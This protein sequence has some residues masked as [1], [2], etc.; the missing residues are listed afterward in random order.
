MFPYAV[1]WLRGYG[2]RQPEASALSME[3]AIKEAFPE[4][5][6][7]LFEDMYGIW[8]EAAYSDH[9]VSEESRLLMKAFMNETIARVN[10]N[11][12]LKDKLRIKLRYAL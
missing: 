10:K 4:S 1:R 8:S 6:A 2:I 3:P 11:C 12:K 9:E 5:Y 7:E